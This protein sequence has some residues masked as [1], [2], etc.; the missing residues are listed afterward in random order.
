MK[1][2]N[3]VA[4]LAA[5]MSI[6]PATAMAQSSVNYSH[7]GR[8]ERMFRPVAGLNNS[9]INFLKYAAATN[10]FEIEAG[11]LAI[12]KGQSSFTKEFGKEMVAD[13]TMTRDQLQQIAQQKGVS[14]P[15]EL[16]KKLQST[17][18][19]LR[20]A[21]GDQFDEAFR[22]CQIDGHADASMM[23]KHE[24]KVGHDEDVK[25]Y[26]VTTLPEITNHYKLAEAKQTMMGDTR[27]DHG[28]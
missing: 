27:A 25:G 21:S 10:E 9:D 20:S 17:L 28:N 13:H 12:D 19:Y 3:A 7:D 26:A 4:F 1:G 8:P 22:R 24:I 16:P 15:A 14:L 18:N 11:Q 2:T 23:F 6:L 5:A